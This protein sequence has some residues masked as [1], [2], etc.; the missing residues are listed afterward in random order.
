[1][2]CKANPDSSVSECR[3]AAKEIMRQLVQ[4]YD[5]AAVALAAEWYDA[6]ATADGASLPS[7]V[8]N[9][10][11]EPDKPDAVARY[12]AKKLV[13]GDVRGFANA[14][15]EYA[16]NDALRNLN[17]TIVRNAARDEGSGVRYARVTRGAS[18]CPFCI[19]LASRG[20]VYH[21]QKSAG[22]F[23]EFHR[24]YRCK[25]VQ[26]FEAD[27]MATLVE[28]HDPTDELRIWDRI[29]KARCAAC[30]VYEKSI[31]ELSVQISHFDKALGESWG[32][33]KNAGGNSRAYRAE[34][35]SAVRRLCGS[36]L[37]KLETSRRSRARSSRRQC[38]LRAWETE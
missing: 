22:E 10:V 14:C 32:R 36:S 15:G 20:A 28:G 27:P 31:D 8:T 26:G 33:F 6:R 1:M 37:I 3:E 13:S 21:S 35:V 5:E 9:V 38:G 29:E 16:A 19:M 30:T 23:R 12:Q 17:E 7:A 4:A 25:V 24:G 2:W 18:C 34:Y 11:Y